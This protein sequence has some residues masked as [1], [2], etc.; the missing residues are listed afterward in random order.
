MAIKKVSRA[1]K[2]E[3]ALNAGQ[4]SAEGLQEFHKKQKEL[5]A[6]HRAPVAPMAPRAPVAPR[7][8]AWKPVGVATR[9]RAALVQ[10][11]AQYDPVYRG[12]QP[13]V[14]NTAFGIRP[15][16]TYGPQVYNPIAYNPITPFYR[17]TYT[18]YRTG[19][20]PLQLLR[21]TRAKSRARSRSR[22]RRSSRSKSRSRRIRSRR[23]NPTSR[24]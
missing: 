11:R 7:A 20:H 15:R 1:R 19:Y 8:P 9:D 10:R 3:D 6:R 4:F 14:T 16:F 22:S 18:T 24:R 12:A 23:I 21:L 5:T 13:A 2:Q 17:P